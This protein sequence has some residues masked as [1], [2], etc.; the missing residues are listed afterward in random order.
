MLHSDG[1]SPLDDRLGAS[2]GAVDVV[3]SFV[4]RRQFADQERRAATA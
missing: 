2:D 3:Q 4:L 1:L